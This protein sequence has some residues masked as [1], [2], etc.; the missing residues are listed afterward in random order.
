MNHAARILPR[1]LLTGKYPVPD[2]L[3]RF[4]IGGQ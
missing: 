2:S 4:T 1:V 3:C